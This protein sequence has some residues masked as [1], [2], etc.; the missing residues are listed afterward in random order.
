M[1]YIPLIISC[2][3]LA[4]SGKPN[5]QALGTLERDRIVLKATAAEIITAA[6]IAEGQNVK[7]GDLL[8]QLDDSNQK[9]QVAK[10]E[11]NVASAKA[12]LA[13]LQ[14]GARREEVASSRTQ[15][16]RTKANLVEA[17]KTFDRVSTLV[18]KKL[19]GIADLDA[20]RAKRDSA[21]AELEQAKQGLLTL[22]NGSR[23]EDIDQAEAQLQ[24]TN[25]ALQLEQ[26]HLEELSIRATR[27][28]RLDRLPKHLGERTNI[29][30]AVAIILAN[31]APYARVYIPETARVKI[32]AGQTINIHVD[33]VK[34]VIAGKVRWVSQDPAF[35]PYYA[36]NS[37]D[38]ARLVYLAEIQLPDSAQNL[39][40]GVPVQ[41]DLANKNE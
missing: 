40:S 15:V 16:T 20:A 34:D 30:D 7:E 31:N 37:S 11:A 19:T 5:T 24:Q 39:P 26:H 1:K 32:T 14:Q 10:A 29:G 8:L 28:G 6:P 27:S 36:L 21:A 33:G 25:A 41:I 35:T 23:E 18:A 17:Q 12:F 3:L 2:C 38:R 22:T 9:N 13:K 4:C